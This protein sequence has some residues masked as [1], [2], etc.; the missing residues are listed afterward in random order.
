M[1]KRIIFYRLQNSQPKAA[2]KT[3]IQSVVLTSML[4]IC[5]KFLPDSILVLHPQRKAILLLFTG[6]RSCSTRTVANLGI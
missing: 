6:S 3:I 4:E 2:G 1:M 5:I